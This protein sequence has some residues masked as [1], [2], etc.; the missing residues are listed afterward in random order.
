M[1]W[2]GKRSLLIISVEEN[3]NFSLFTTFIK[4]VSAIAINLIVITL[5]SLLIELTSIRKYIDDIVSQIVIDID[6][7]IANKYTWDYSSLE[8]E[9][10]EEHLYLVLE[11]IAKK[12]REQKGIS[13]PEENDM[14]SIQEVT[15]N[16]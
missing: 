16:I 6:K 9:D 14:L 2:I 12:G 3:K 11:E 5:I 4:G 7:L 8:A 13:I 10:L 1:I 15:W